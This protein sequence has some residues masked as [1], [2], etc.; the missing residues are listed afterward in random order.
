MIRAPVHQC[1]SRACTVVVLVAAITG[2]RVV[3]S[4]RCF[5]T[6]RESLKG[7]TRRQPTD[8]S[9]DTI[10]YWINWITDDSEQRETKVST[11][12]SVSNVSPIPIHSRFEPETPAPFSKYNSSDRTFLRVKCTRARDSH[13]SLCLLNSRF[14]NFVRRV[15]AVVKKREKEKERK[16]EK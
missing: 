2:F 4:W 10:R 5:V 1:M 15:I 11:K 8:P 9:L 16:K 3:G 13:L 6:P 7:N 12:E 14:G